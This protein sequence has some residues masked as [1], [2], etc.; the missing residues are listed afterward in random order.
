MADTFI[1]VTCYRGTF[2]EHRENILGKICLL[3]AN[4]IWLVRKKENTYTFLFNT[5]LYFNTKV[6]I[7]FF[8]VIFHPCCNSCI[9]IKKNSLQVSGVPI[10]HHDWLFFQSPLHECDNLLTKEIWKPLFSS[11]AEHVLLLFLKH[12]HPILL[13]RYFHYVLQKYRR[14]YGN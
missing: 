1:A 5:F 6:I 4:T 10:Q 14:S 9:F 11:L 12:I 3:I 13:Q 7:Q 2:F 8:Q